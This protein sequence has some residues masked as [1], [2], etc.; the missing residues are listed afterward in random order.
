MGDIPMPIMA[1]VRLTQRQWLKP[2][3]T[4]FM[5]D[6]MA[7]ILDMPDITDI[8]MLIMAS[9]R[10]N[11][12]PRLKPTPTFFMVDIMVIILDMPDI[13][14]ILMVIMESARLRPSLKLT[15]LFSMVDTMDTTW[16][17]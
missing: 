5:E 8:L 11:Q 2:T 16:D 17:M 15:L 13:T 6:I 12:R 4:F 1:S 3:P 9:V 10:L 14:D 7:T